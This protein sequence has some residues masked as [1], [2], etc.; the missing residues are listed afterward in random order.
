MRSDA[1][2]FIDYLAEAEQMLER[3]P[4][5]AYAGGDGGLDYRSPENF[6]LALFE[7]WSD[8]Y[9]LDLELK[10][11]VRL[12]Q[13]LSCSGGTLIC[14]CLAGLPNVSVLSEV[15]PLSKLHVESNPPG[16]AP[17][18]LV[19]LCKRSNLPDIEELQENIFKAEMAVIAKH[20]RT[21]GKHLLIREHSH[22]DYMEGTETRGSSTVKRLLQDQFPVLSILTVRHPA[23]S[24]LSLDQLG[25]KRFAPGTFDEYCRRYS[26]F[27]EH[28]KKTPLYKYEDFVNDPQS[29]MRRICESL[30]LP[31]NE[32]FEDVFDIYALS[33][34]SGRTSSVI[35]KRE[36][37]AYED[38]FKAELDS[39][40]EYAELCERLD[41]P[42]SLE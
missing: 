32:D 2:K 37:R 7:R 8:Y 12:V 1:Q 41:Y 14:K 19:Y 33:G 29:E 10:P 18:D 40:A 25:W 21:L 39:S 24:Y 31:F 5:V 9:E 11:V 20:A 3:H 28:N 16:F 13:H 4:L 15:N 36:R 17:S 6:N 22:S 34:D 30:E 35:Q 38:S 26:L 42:T 23:D 27:I